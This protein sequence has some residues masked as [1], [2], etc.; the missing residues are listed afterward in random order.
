MTGQMSIFDYM[1]S[2]QFSFDN[3]IN[4]IVE[5][6]D[7]LVEKNNLKAEK[8]WT[9]WQH[10]PGFGYRL[11]YDIS[12]HTLTEEFMMELDGIIKY[13]GKK[14]IRLSVYRDE[15]LIADDGYRHMDIYSTF[16]DKKRRKIK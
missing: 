14:K 2:P 3:D 7:Q 10:V 11:A 6:L 8:E 16:M 1:E 4:T 13:A 15:L 5:M 12:Y 9:V